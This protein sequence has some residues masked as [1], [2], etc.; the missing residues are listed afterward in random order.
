MRT[1]IRRPVVLAATAVAALS[2]SLTACGGEDGTKSDGAA[3]PASASKAADGG[4]GT[5]GSGTGGSD[6]AGG[7]EKAGSKTAGSGESGSGDVAAQAGSKKKPGAKAPAC[8]ADDVKVSAAKQE[9]VP[10]THIT[11]TAKNVSARACTLL[12]YPLLAF[13]ELP[14]TSKDVPAVAKSNPGVPIVLEAGA[15]A[16]AAVRINNGGVDDKNHAVTSFYVNFF[17]TDGPAEGS[18]SVTAP[19]GGIAVDDAA[20]KTGYWT[21]ELRNGA[22]DF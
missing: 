19:K 13:G 16:Y 7:T 1:S 18:E 12:K 3:K 11:L 5:A 15:P 17:A 8:T 14:Q 2:L 10:T 9:G 22:D 20:A 4:A 6:T 21:S